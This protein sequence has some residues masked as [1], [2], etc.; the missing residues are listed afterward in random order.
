MEFKFYQWDLYLKPSTRMQT[1]AL[2]H[3]IQNHRDDIS[4]IGLIDLDEFFI[5]VDKMKDRN[6]SSILKEFDNTEVGMIKTNFC[7]RIF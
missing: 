2:W 5:P 1:V 7:S 6:I 3:C 4:W